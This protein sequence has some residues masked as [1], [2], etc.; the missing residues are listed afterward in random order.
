MYLALGIIF[1]LSF[2]LCSGFFSLSQIALFSLSSSELKLYKT[3]KDPIR[4]L[5]F[6]LLSKPKELL[7]TLL[8]CDIGANILI[9]NTTANLFKEDAGWALTVGVPLVITL[10]FGELFP[11]TIALPN[12]AKI[13][14]KVAPLIYFLEKLLGPLR[15]LLTYI[16]THLS[17]V[18]FFFLK[19]EEE[20]SKDELHHV[21]KTSHHHGV[22]STDEAELIDGYLSLDDFTV[23]ERM[24]PR[25]EILFYEMGEPLSKLT[26]LFSEMQCSRVPV[27][28]DDLQNLEGII[29]AHD[30][31]IH[32][33]QIKE[34][35]DLLPFLTKPYFV[36][37]TI[38]AKTLLRQFLQTEKTMG[39][40]IDEYG[41]ITGLITQE[42]LF[43]VVVGEIT[44]RRDEKVRYTPA[45]KDIIITSGK[46]E[47]SEFEELFGVALPSENNMVTLGGWLTEQVG[48]IPK[49]GTKFVWKNFLFQVLAADPTRVR[50][51]YIRRTDGKP[52]G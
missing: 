7:V 29:S 30:F 6:L 24:H 36:P 17:R 45:G 10:F 4:Q 42:D 43:E 35:K 13:S 33:H 41:T 18:L 12:N 48:D 2:T 49:S 44:D 52:H 50:R 11:K 51:I 34:G 21:L 22:L 28:L 32:R 8:M 37:E 1:L 19:K 15:I 16:T 20:I 38:L 46:F 23:K 9:Q 25:H 47:L 39:V 5:I 14:Y 27:C 31:F 3:D 40:V 26:Y